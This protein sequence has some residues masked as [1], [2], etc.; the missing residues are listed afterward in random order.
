MAASDP[1]SILVE[2]DEPEGPPTCQIR[3]C[4]RPSID[5]SEPDSTG[6]SDPPRRVHVCRRHHRIIQA[7]KVGI[8]AGAILIL[9][10][11]LYMSA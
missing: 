2:A 8:A 11:A 9:V 1:P 4:D 10:L 5:E 6:E 3:G 7:I